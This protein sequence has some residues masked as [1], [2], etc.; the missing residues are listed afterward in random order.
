MIVLFI[1]HIKR[2]RRIMLSFVNCL[3]LHLSFLYHTRHNVCKY[4]ENKSNVLIFSTTSSKTFLTLR[5]ERYII[6]H[7]HKSARYT[8]HV[9]I[10]F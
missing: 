10:K 4:T 8:C 1:R 9:S 5:A 7:V 2:L 3:T 6:K